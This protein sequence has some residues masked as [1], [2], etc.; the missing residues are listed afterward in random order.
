MCAP[1][2]IESSE[3]SCT[4][5]VIISGA[6]PAGLLMASLLLSRN[7]EQQDQQDLSN[8]YDVTLLDGREDYGSFT[9]EELCANHRSWMLGLADHGMDAIKTL[10]ELYENYVKGEGILVR[11]FNLF[12]GK[13]K[14]KKQR[15]TRT[16]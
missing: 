14:K 15:K 13:K 2:E 9:K 5:R 3:T 16:D 11:E 12:L 8:F 7:K 6:G 4:K 10:P 1:T